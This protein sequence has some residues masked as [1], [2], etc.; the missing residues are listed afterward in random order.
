VLPAGLRI[1][2]DWLGRSEEA[3]LAARLSRQ[4]FVDVVMRGQIARR[5]V[6]HFGVDYGYQSRA[7]RETTPPPEWLLS[8]RE[9]AGALAGVSGAELVEVLI[10]H[11]PAG[12]G[13]GWH[14]DAPM[15][16]P[17]VGISL[18][19]DCTL[20]FRKPA[21]DG[22]ERSELALPA[23]S[24]YLLSDAVRWA[25]QHSIPA[26]KQPRYSITFRTLRADARVD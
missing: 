15:F 19:G 1:A 10:T 9:R 21:A 16:G 2:I 4:P 13:I 22:Y 5:K 11:Y 26:V 14:R 17:V 20:R 3:E 25:W 24:A 7:I 23:R 8:L 18:L 6:L 12:A